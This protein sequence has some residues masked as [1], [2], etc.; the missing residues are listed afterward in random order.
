[1]LA[2]AVRLGG[3]DAA[4]VMTS[5]IVVINAILILL[6]AWRLAGFVAAAVAATATV[7]SAYLNGFGSTLYLDPAQCMFLLAAL[8]CMCEA[9]RTHKL[10]WFA[11]AGVSSGLAFLVKESAIQWLPLAALAWL[12]MPTMRT[13]GVAA[14]TAVYTGSFGLLVSAWSGWVWLQTGDLFLLGEPTTL[15]LGALA[16]ALTVW[17]TFAATVAGWSRVP[18]RMR[19]HL[20]RWAPLAAGVLVLGWS[21]FLLYGLTAYSTWPFPNHYWR[22]VPNYMV[23]VAPQV[24]P[25]YLVTLAW[26]WAAVHAARGD[27]R[28]RVLLV[29]AV[30]F[31]PFAVFMANRGL[32]LRDALPLVYLSYVL[33]GVV[34][35]HAYHA[36]RGTFRDGGSLTL[37]IVT[38]MVLA[39]AFVAHQVR[40][41]G[42]TNADRSSVGTRADSW[43]N[44]FALALAEWMSRNLPEGSS[45]MTSRLYFSSLHVNTDGRFTIRQLPTVR[46]DLDARREPLVEARSNLF[47]WGETRVRPTEVDDTWLYL[48]QYDGKGYWVGL[49]QQELLEYTA[50]HDV[51]Y[52]V[53]TGEDIVFSTAV[54]IDYFLDHPAFTLLHHTAEPPL[55]HAFV[56]AVDLDRLKRVPHVTV[57]GPASLRAAAAQ[58][59]LTPAELEARL[60]TPLRVSDLE[61]GLSAGESSRLMT[62]AADGRRSQSCAGFF[63]VASAHPREFAEC[64]HARQASN[65]AQH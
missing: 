18:E 15:K 22:T 52:L 12:A 40:E 51:Q 17:A 59:G 58:T 23:T 41:F 30:L 26:V 20:P 47:R 8:V 31:A 62:D 64:S 65:S 38:S 4:Y 42:A 57:M 37:V 5:A 61:Y 10:R 55:H 56:F 28:Y 50:T 54:Y 63:G 44:P 48:K 14:G 16:V 39:G 25:F 60:A 1:M 34:A 3:P 6:L 21:A 19:E 32:Q 29:A 33:L 35:A 24:Q 2:P 11:L 49:A 46:V 45:V 13:R 7:A 43:N 36:F 27:E 53:I 9:M